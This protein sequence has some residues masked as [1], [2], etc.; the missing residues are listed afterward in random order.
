MLGTSVLIL[1]INREDQRVLEAVRAGASGYLLK[2][3]E[4][5]DIVTGDSRR[6]RRQSV[7]A[8]AAAGG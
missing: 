2:D 4:L 8:P 5:D 1:T 7:L 6:C 3:A